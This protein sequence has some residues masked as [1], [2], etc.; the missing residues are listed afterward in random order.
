MER[1][2]KLVIDAWFVAYNKIVKIQNIKPYNIY[3][4]DKS[5]FS[6]G[7][8]NLTQIIINSTLYTKY[9]AHPGRQE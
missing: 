6:I 3:N 4:M 5:G 8:I 7:T 2:T 1:A 9:Q